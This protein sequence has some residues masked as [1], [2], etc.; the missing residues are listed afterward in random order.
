RV[1]QATES[2]RLHDYISG[3][4]Q[5]YESL[6]GERGISLSGGQRQRLSISRSTLLLPSVL[7]LDDA[8]SAIDAVT[9]NQIRRSLIDFAKSCAT[10]IISHRL[11]SLMHA[12]EILFL[13]QGEVV[14]RGT[15]DELLAM[16]GR[17][18]ALYELQGVG[19]GDHGDE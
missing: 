1:S 14:E 18:K 7:V 10:I 16:N 17:Y 15:H 11:S 19:G 6:V 4:P 2:A 3:L 12:N 5:G 9:E 13:E 8:T